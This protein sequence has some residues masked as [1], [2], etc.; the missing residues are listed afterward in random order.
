MIIT[1]TEAGVVNMNW[2][3]KYHQ[4]AH[5]AEEID[6]HLKDVMDD[7][8]AAFCNR[9][10]MRGTY[11]QMYD[12]FLLHEQRLIH[13]GVLEVT[14]DI[15]PDPPPGPDMCP[16]CAQTLDSFGH[17]NL[18]PR[19]AEDACP[20]STGVTPSTTGEI[21]CTLNTAIGQR[22]IVMAAESVSA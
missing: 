20:L 11:I 9:P 10:M 1:A 18:C 5:T 13:E 8:Q 12:A 17:L 7:I 22:T 21:R 15:I 2:C 19:G 14:G 6:K 4:Y 3:I 16:D